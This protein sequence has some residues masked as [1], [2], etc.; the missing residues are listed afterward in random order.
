MT[1]RLEN[2]LGLP[3]FVDGVGE[4]YPVKVK[5]YT[6]LMDN[7]TYLM[8]PKSYFY[9]IA[10][11]KELVNEFYLL[12]LVVQTM[13]ASGTLNDF[14][15]NCIEVFKLV[16]H[17]EVVYMPSKTRHE[18]G[19]FWILKGNSEEDG[20]RKIDKYNYDEIRG[21]IL[22]QNVIHEKKFRKTVAAQKIADRVMAVRQK[23]SI[24]ITIEDVIT[25]VGVVKGL[26]YDQ[27]LNQTLYQLYAD[28]K[29]IE[30][31]KEYDKLIQYQCV[32]EKIDLKNNYFAGFIDMNVNPWDD[33]FKRK[34]DS[35][36]TNLI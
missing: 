14:I 6:K 11:N 32:G 5:D 20:K 31:M 4:I 33:V 22:S 9:Q 26:T 10:E 24:K 17:S 36:M 2:I 35:K 21:L 15:N 7:I 25:T 13:Q 1:E 12:D 18:F 3:I 16:T 34:E 29:R 27:I 28:Y 19:E 23:N 30:K 8:I